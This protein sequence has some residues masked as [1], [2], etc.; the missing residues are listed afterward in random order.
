MRADASALPF[1]SGVFDLAT[2]ILGLEFVAEPGRALQE[3]HRVLTPGG[4]LV[5]AILNRS[6]LWTLW[7]RLKRRLVP[8]IWREARFLGADE[9][10]H[11]LRARGF[12]AQ[13]WRR[14]VHSLPLLARERA[15]WLERW[16]AIGARW[17]PGWAAFVAVAARRA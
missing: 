8:S 12:A 7:R 17:M 13:R 14:A 16:E 1:R 2:M 4:C 10:G 5:T 9:L 6:G 11:L 15:R 3:A